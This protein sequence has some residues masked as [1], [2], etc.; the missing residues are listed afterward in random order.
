MNSFE[1][2]RIDVLERRMGLLER[3]VVRLGGRAPQ[4]APAS[5]PAA[6]PAPARVEPEP[7][8]V[9]PR[10]RPARPP[11]EPRFT[12]EALFGA[13]SLAITGGIVTLLGILFFFVLAVN[14]GWIGPGARVALGGLASTTV[15]S[16]GLWLRRRFGETYS[17]FAAVGVGIAGGYATLLAATALYCLLPNAA[18]LVVSAGIALAGTATALAWRSELIAGLGLVGAALTPLAIAA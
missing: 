14:R 3:E 16:A 11:R 17:A 13:R 10:P 9:A 7:V 1:S 8:L 5:Q 4:V 15:F 2:D 12:F 6:R 18:G